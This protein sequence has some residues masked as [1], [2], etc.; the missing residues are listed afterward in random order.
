M[1]E[2][3]DNIASGFK[4]FSLRRSFAKVVR[5]PAWAQSEDHHQSEKNLQ[6]K[7]TT[8]ILINISS[9]GVEYT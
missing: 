5:V 9:F 4:C 8:V 1:L 2:S 6:L 7:R 3:N